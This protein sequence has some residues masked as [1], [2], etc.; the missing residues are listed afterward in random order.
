MS[1]LG[2]VVSLTPAGTGPAEGDPPASGGQS[3]APGTSYYIALGD[4]LAA[5][6]Q[7]DGTGRDRPTR[8]GYVDAVAAHLKKQVPALHTIKLGGTGTSSTAIVGPPV[9]SRYPGSS[10]LDQAL[11]LIKKHRSH[12]AL[13]TVNIGDNDVETCI[14]P[15]GID[16]GCVRRGLD[17]VASNLATIGKAL[18]SKAGKRV[19]IVGVSDYDQFWAYW[20]HG[21]TARSIAKSSVKVVRRLNKT[22]DSSWTSANVLSADAAPAFHTFDTSPA[23]LAGYGTVPRAVE[24]ICHLTWACSGPPIGFD[25]HANSGGYRL[26][27]RAVIAQLPH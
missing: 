20:L 17:A 6:V 26:I 7:P 14:G 25:D 1:L 23:Q 10:Q 27:A 5:G 8:K 12:I 13:I 11:R 21:G 16:H 2:L 3:A 15:D 22:I 19:P 9:T 18:R 4:S 24:R